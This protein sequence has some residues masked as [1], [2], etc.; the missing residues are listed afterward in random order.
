MLPSLLAAALAVSAPVPKFTP[1]LADVFGEPTAAKGDCTLSMTG[2]GVLRVTVPDTHPR[3]DGSLAGRLQ[4]LAAKS[5]SENF[6]LTVRLTLGPLADTDAQRPPGSLLP[7]AGGGVAV[8]AESD[9]VV[10]LV[11]GIE[12]QRGPK[13]W[14]LCRRVSGCEHV[15]GKLA[16]SGRTTD[17]GAVPSR[18]CGSPAGGRN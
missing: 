3:A 8:R 10:G 15:R 13:G 9:P 4:S 5:T 12:R 2:R 6:V 11:A 7:C 16:V 1:S 18:T 17:G 14:V